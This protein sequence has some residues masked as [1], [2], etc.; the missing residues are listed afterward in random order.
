MI[1]NDLA[2]IHAKSEGVSELL[3]AVFRLSSP[4]DW[5][6]DAD[7]KRRVSTFLLLAAP[8]T[9]PKEHIDLI[10]QISAALIE[11]DFVALLKRGSIKKIRKSLEFLL[12]E[13]LISRTNVCL[14]GVHGP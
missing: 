4:V 3:M 7:E 11:D 13:E 9:A 14:K 1:I 2:L 12:S 5:R 10:S 8:P 6:N